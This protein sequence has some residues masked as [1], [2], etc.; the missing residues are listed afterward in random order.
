M[1]TVHLDPGGQAREALASAV[2][3]FGPQI[4]S[5]PQMLENVF[6]DLLPDSPREV[7]ILV[8]AAQA[9]VATL[10]QDRVGQHMDPDTAVRLTASVL[11]ERRALDATAC[12][13]ATAEFARALGYTIT[14]AAAMTPTDRLADDV[15]DV[16]GWGQE[17][18]AAPA[19]GAVLAGG[20]AAGAAPADAQP[21]SAPPAGGATPA[22]G[23]TPPGTGAGFAG[24]GEDDR[25]RT[26]GVG[27]PHEGGLFTPAAAAGGAAGAAAAGGGAGKP[28]VD[29]RRLLLGAGAV[30]VVVVVVVVV[31]L[32]GNKPK[33]SSDVT[34]TTR[35]TTTTHTTSPPTTSTQNNTTT[36]T[37][38][39]AGNLTAL[40]Q[41]VPGDDQDPSTCKH[42]TVTDQEAPLINN[43]IQCADPDLSTNIFAFQ[44]KTFADYEGALENVN[45]DENFDPQTV[46]QECPAGSASQGIESYSF[47]DFP[48]REGQVVECFIETSGSLDGDLTYLWTL[49]SQNTY[50]FTT[51]PGGRA[52]YPAIEQWWAEQSADPQF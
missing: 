47:Q 37:P 34:T 4:L 45:S 18:M 1:S 8:T 52:E 6:R 41:L 7:S 5:N 28:P 49:P 46:A 32:V 16:R 24:A 2:A 51:E 19:E 40:T 9:D 11:G 30:V 26:Q 29:R 10:L 23:A 25:T 21:A 3:N 39:P 35:P 36:T 43:S 33:H 15:S 48:A 38:G 31:L 50:M 17:S 14:E 27:Q 44:F 12:Q 13:W 42:Y 20:A 22:A